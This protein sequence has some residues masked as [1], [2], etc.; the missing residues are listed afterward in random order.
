MTDWPAE[1]FEQRRTRLRAVAL[2]DPERLR[3]LDLTVLDDQ[4][5]AVGSGAGASSR[6]KRPLGSRPSSRRPNSIPRCSGPTAVNRTTARNTGI[7]TISMH[8]ELDRRVEEDGGDQR[9]AAAEAVGEQAEQQ[10][11]DGTG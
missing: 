1:E 3:R 2:A 10:R 8:G 9:L 6:A 4:R 7:I 11:A 5:R